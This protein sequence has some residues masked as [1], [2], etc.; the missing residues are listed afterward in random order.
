MYSLR[1]SAV[2]RVR[3]IDDVPMELLHTVFMIGTSAKDFIARVCEGQTTPVCLD[4][5]VS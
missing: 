3:N 5:T 4:V 2:Y 1:C